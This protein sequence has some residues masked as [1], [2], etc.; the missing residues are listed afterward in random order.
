MM[1]DEAKNM[2]ELVRA[3]GLSAPAESREVSLQG[4]ENAENGATVVCASRDLAKLEAVVAE[5]V[6]ALGPDRDA[7]VLAASIRNPMHAVI[8]ARLIGR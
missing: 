6:E 5:I 7:Q 4:P 2:A 3:L 1:R 8:A